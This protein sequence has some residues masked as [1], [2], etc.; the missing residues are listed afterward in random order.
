LTEWIIDGGTVVDPKY[1]FE[2][3][4]NPT[5]VSTAQYD[6]HF[7]KWTGD[8]DTQMTSAREFY[9]EYTNTIR[10]Y[11]VYFYNDTQLL[12]TVE[13]VPYG[14]STSYS[15]S[16]P[17][18]L[19]VENPEE[20]IFKGWLPT[21]TNITGE[22]T[23]YALFKFNGYIKD[24]WTVIAENVDNGNAP[25]VYQIGARKEIPITL[26]GEDVTIDVEIISFCHDYLSDGSAKASIIFFCKDLPNILHR[27]NPESTNAGGWEESEMR[28][29][30]NNDLYDALP[31]DLKR[32][33]L[34]VRKI[35]D[36]GSSNKNLVTTD[37]KLWLASYNE[38]GLTSGNNNL[39]GHGELYSNVFS[40]DKDSRK[41]YIT[42]NTA[43]GGWWLRSS[44]YSDNT[45]SMFWR[46]T[47]GGGSYSDIAFNKFYVAFGFCIGVGG[48]LYQFAEDPDS[49]GIYNN[50][51]GYKNNTYL[52]SDSSS[53]TTD[54]VTAA[55]V[56]ST[57]AMKYE[58]PTGKAPPTIVIKG[59]EWQSV[60]T[61]R[62]RFLGSN[63]KSTLAP[64]IVGN[65]SGST[66]LSYNY[67]IQSIADKH[68]KLIPNVDGNGKWVAGGGAA[69][70]LCKY[71]RIS[72]AG[73]GENLNIT[74]ENNA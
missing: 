43:S 15:G 56:V 9:A 25:Y 26:D 55:A 31:D 74:F 41:K 33:I 57:G 37:D 30:V 11:N 5:R 49:D 19:G 8:F 24:D 28:Q 66:S 42:D 71:I 72:L 58:C 69:T 51:L 12:Y 61:C 23:C 3:Y 20:Y 10:R 18:K 13:N 40:S 73:V 22:T 16:T 29:F 59:A 27:M 67:T 44:Y 2:D 17:T 70:S 65:A 60:S 39:T 35:S 21:P 54:G 46:V 38:V 47:N 64:W 34:P 50:G 7:S 36:G 32:I 68:F 6:Y 62:I 53:N 45:S 14:G 1:Y 4:I 52:S 63:K 48:N